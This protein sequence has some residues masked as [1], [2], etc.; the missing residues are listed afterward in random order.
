MP[1]D[2]ITNAPSQNALINKVNEIIDKKQDNLPS[3]AG[4]NGKFLTTNGST[5]SWAEGGN[6]L[7]GLS[8]VSIS[9]PETGQFLRYN[10]LK[11]ENA[12]QVWTYNSETENLTID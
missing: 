5:L 1:I 9:S 10:G 12:S 7:E 3:Q 2:K 4:N 11:W 6:S 8:D